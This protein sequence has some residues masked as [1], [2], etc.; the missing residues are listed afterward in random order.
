M[1]VLCSQMLESVFKR[2]TN[3]ATNVTCGQADT[4]SEE[5]STTNAQMDTVSGQKSA[6]SEKTNTPGG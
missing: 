3:S 1:P 2:P 5:T 4:T 6:T